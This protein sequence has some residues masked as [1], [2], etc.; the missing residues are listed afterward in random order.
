MPSDPFVALGEFV[1]ASEA[2]RLAATFAAGRTTEQ[3]LNQVHSSRR[4][5]MRSLLSA[6]AVGHGTAATAIF[7]AIEGAKSVHRD[8][9][10]VWTT[11]GATSRVGHLTS[12]FPRH[13]NH[14]RQSITCATY[15]FQ[16]SSGIWTLL[17][18]ASERSDVVVT[19]Y[20]DGAVA[21]GQLVK[22]RLPRA[23]VYRST[24]SDG[25]PS[26]HVRS[27][28]KFI[29]IDHTVLLLTSANFSFSAEHNNVEFGLLVHDEPLAESVEREMRD[30]HGTIYELV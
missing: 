7:R 26:G 17:K 28:A 4:S 10:P 15:N 24:S 22:Q 12:E 8:L 2:A 9:I 14:A 21:D 6:A 18:E 16:P 25:R 11:P 13:L 5:A 1:T 27:H 20:V 23:V 29:I 3:A 30:K 19:L